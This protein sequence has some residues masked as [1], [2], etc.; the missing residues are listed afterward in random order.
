VKSLHPGDQLD[1]YRIEGSV[2]SSGMASV[3]RGT[4][5][6]SGEPVAIKIPHPQAEC[7]PIFFD[8][9]RR[10]AEIGREMEHPA[11]TR[12][13]PDQDQSRV[14][15]AMEWV[16]GRLLRQVLADEGTLSPHRATLIAI[17]VCEALEYLHS[18][19]IVHR[20]LK[21]E[22]VM[23]GADDRIKLIDFGIAAKAGARRL[24]FGKLSHV[25]GTAEY[26]S[27]EQ[28]KGGR[29]DPRSDI[30]AVGIMLYEMLT[31]K[32]PFRGDNPFAVMNAR[33]V[34][35]PIPLRQVDPQALPALE[36]ILF[37]ALEYDP[38]RRYS[39]AREF[40]NDLKHPDQICPMPR[41]QRGQEPRSKQV[42]FYSAL[43]MIP[44]TIFMLLLYVASR[45]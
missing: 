25:M 26:I 29:G 6:R 18:H 11:V 16:E 13:L 23:I 33:L 3:F 31:G 28:L 20:D 4:D 14:Y 45:H 39:N 12:V 22:N 5:L 34:S 44:A 2:A 21:P 27:P 10:E 15:M 30:Y 36:E 37:R 42:L 35:D 43:A 40:A 24:T 41:T 1:H 8:R 9:F 32:T 19:G 7:D 17:G 38:R